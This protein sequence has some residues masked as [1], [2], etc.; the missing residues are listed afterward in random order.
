M[1]KI[2]E[3][4]EK[5]AQKAKNEVITQFDVSNEVMTQISLL[6][7]EQPRLLPIEI[8]ASVSAIAA[9]IVIFFSMN[10]FQCIVNPLFQLFTPYQ[11]ASL[12]W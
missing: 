5:L 11:G 10:A 12:P 1:D 8:F 4:V 7:Y 3:I 9:S 2:I 6:H